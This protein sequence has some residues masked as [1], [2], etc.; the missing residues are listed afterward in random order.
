MGP[1]EGERVRRALGQSGTGL[2]EV[3]IALVLASLTVLALVQALFTL[4][5]TTGAT[6]DRQQL[7]SAVGGYGESLK[8]VAWVACGPGGTPTA[9]DYADAESASAAPFHAPR[10]VTL[11][12]TRVQYWNAQTASFDATCPAGGTRAQRLD[13]RASSSR[14]S[15]G[16]QVVKVP[17]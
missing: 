5:A 2:V 8:Q 9:A 4:I 11:S 12:V 6:A 3:L 7:A 10:G 14:G 1:Q 15:Y 16:A 13:V 17:W